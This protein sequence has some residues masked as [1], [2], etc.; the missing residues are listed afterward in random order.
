[1]THRPASSCLPIRNVQTAS[2][3]SS[4]VMQWA[5]PIGMGFSGFEHADRAGNLPVLYDPGLADVSEVHAPA[6]PR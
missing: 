3:C 1:M 6:L 4:Q 2:P 5:S